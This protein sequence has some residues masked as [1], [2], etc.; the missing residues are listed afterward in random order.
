MSPAE[1][2]ASAAAGARARRQLEAERHRQ[3]RQLLDRLVAGEL[4]ELQRLEPLSVDV[5]ARLE[6]VQLVA[7]RARQAVADEAEGELRSQ[8]ERLELLAGSL[9]ETVRRW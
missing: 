1:R 8:L 7:A 4:A 2:R 3:R 9:A 5:L 6:A